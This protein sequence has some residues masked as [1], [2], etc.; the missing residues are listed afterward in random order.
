MSRNP[1][2]QRI[3][4]MAVN[5]DEQSNG[6]NT[7]IYETRSNRVEKLHIGQAMNA[8]EGLEV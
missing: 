5:H 6:E 2:G 3:S 7:C 8:Q 4:Y 1:S